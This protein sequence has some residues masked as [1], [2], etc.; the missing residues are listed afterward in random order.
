M[1]TILALILT[2][3]L[4][5]AASAQCSGGVCKA[6]ARKV[7]S[8]V[9]TTVRTAER[10]RVPRRFNRSHWFVKTRIIHRRR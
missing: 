6:P 5:T 9:R 1:K 10:V 4:T 3:T 8:V 2:L 7:V